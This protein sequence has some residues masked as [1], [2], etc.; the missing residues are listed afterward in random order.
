MRTFII[1]AGGIGKRMGGTQPKQFLLLAGEPVLMHTLRKLALFDPEAQLILT[2]PE[3]HL[4]SWQKLCKQHQF[5][6]PH[7]VVA[8]GE[9][10]FHSVQNA[11]T[12][13]KGQVIAVHDGV[14]PFV[15]H[16]TLQ[17]LFEAVEKHPAVIPVVPVKDSMRQLT[18]NGNNAVNRN[19][20]V[21]IQTPQVFNAGILREAYLQPFSSSFTDDA[22]V[23]EAAGSEI[24]LV[25]G[26]EENMKLT[27]PSDL[28]IAEALLGL[29][30]VK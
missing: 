14:R 11:L 29:P 20:F 26:N 5:S 23:V 15:T 1:T 3:A 13:C 17:R 28:W 24:H 30:S 2:L 25:A 21:L 22:S 8:G 12:I 10:R 9:E 19:E 7:E 4:E 6:L 16:A 27:N 18:E